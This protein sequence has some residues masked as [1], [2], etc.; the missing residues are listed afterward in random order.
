[1]EILPNK[2]ITKYFNFVPHF[3]FLLSFWSF[4]LNNESVVH[5]RN[6]PSCSFLIESQCLLRIAGGQVPETIDVSLADWY[7]PS[8]T[9]WKITK[10]ESMVF[11]TNSWFSRIILIT[12]LNY[13][14]LSQSNCFLTKDIYLQTL[15]L[16]FELYNHS[17]LLT[18]A[19]ILIDVL[20]YSDFSP[21]FLSIFLLAFSM[22]F[23]L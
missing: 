16:T 4:H 19:V 6:L 11:V 5:D 10:V 2:E 1:M 22:I 8:C 7:S 23:I 13:L 17:L 15:D 14:S 18:L 21:S 20:Y 3:C 12:K 9:T